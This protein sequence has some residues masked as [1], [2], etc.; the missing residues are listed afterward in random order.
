VGI[1]GSWHAELF[2]DRPRQAR[3]DLFVARQGGRLVHRP[4]PLRVFRPADSAAAVIGQ[5]AFEARRFTP[6]R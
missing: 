6:R 2:A 5:V 4:A 1:T 3:T